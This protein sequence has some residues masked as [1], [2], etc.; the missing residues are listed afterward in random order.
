KSGA[1]AALINN[2]PLAGDIIDATKEGAN[3][4]F[5]VSVKTR[6][7]YEKVD[8]GWHEFLFNKNL[9]MLTIHGRTKR[10]MS[11]VPAHWD[12]IGTIRQL[13]DELAPETL[14]VG[15]GDVMNK[16]QAMNL[17][18]KYKLDGVMIGRGIF[19]NPLLFA[20]NEEWTTKTPKEKLELYKIHAELFIKTYK[21]NEKPI[22]TLNKFCKTYVNGFDGAKEIRDSLMHATSA[23]DL[24]LRIDQAITLT[25]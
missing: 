15:N 17:A 1:C 22:V 25:S 19:S 4:R 14:I 16:V 12:D 6:L 23:E 10:E 24:Q 21:H 18:K 7:G 11:K 9:N 3:G 13:R 5:P 8:F 2:K 20:A